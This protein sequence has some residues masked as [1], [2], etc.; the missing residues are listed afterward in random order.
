VDASALIVGILLSI[1]VMVEAK[2]RAAMAPEGERC[3]IP[4]TRA[5]DPQ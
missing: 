3:V 5:V 2:P 4:F 1:A